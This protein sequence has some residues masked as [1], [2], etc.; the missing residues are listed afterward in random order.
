LVLARIKTG[1]NRRLL[2]ISLSS[3]QYK[4]KAEKQRLEIQ[5]ERIKK[6]KSPK[7][8]EIQKKTLIRIQKMFFLKNCKKCLRL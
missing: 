4:N 3:M 7:K 1:E 8:C 2:S 5:S 6:E